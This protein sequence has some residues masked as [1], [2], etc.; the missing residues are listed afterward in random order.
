MSGETTPAAPGLVPTVALYVLARL[1]LLGLLV[2][3]L[4]LAGVPVLIATLVGLVVALPLSMVL[5]RGLRAR[6]DAALAAANGRR[7]TEREA[8]R[9][10]LRGDV[11]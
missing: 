3:V 1:G 2:L 6:L 9:A 5:F 10:R 4:S 7:S 11:E 8:L